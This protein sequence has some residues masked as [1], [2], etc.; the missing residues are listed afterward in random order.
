MNPKYNSQKKQLEEK[1]ERIDIKNLSNIYRI[2]G[3]E[4]EIENLELSIAKSSSSKID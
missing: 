3:I 2:W 1:L 4:K